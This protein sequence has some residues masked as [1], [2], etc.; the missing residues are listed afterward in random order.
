M[1]SSRVH[2]TAQTAK[3]Q[4]SRVHQT[5]Q[6]AKVQ[7]SR[8][9]QTAQTA[10]VQSSRV[11]QTAQTARSSHHASIADIHCRHP[12]STAIAR[13]LHSQDLPQPCDHQITK[14]HC[15][16]MPISTIIICP[17][18]PSSRVH[19]HSHHVA[20]STVIISPFPRSTC[21]HLTVIAYPFPMSTRPFPPSS[22]LF[23]SPGYNVLVDWA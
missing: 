17:F 23:P 15:R 11:H 6:T 20:I 22:R 18:P 10:K 19:F 7:S 1:Q 3:I 21:I 13:L 4:S 14:I 16:H 9:H 12:G 5:A 8:V 2:Q